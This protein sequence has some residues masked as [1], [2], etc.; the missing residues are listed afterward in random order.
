MPEERVAEEEFY[1]EFD[2]AKLIAKIQSQ[3]AQAQDAGAPAASEE[4]A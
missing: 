4:E 1:E 2:P 3:A